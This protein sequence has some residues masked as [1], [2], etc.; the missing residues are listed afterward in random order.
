MELCLVVVE[1]TLANSIAREIKTQKTLSLLT[2]GL[3][4]LRELVQTHIPLCTSPKIPSMD[5]TPI[6]STPTRQPLSPALPDEFN[7][8]QIKGETSLTS[9]QTYIHLCPPWTRS[10]SSGPCPILSLEE[11]ENGQPEFL[12]GRKT[13][14]DIPNSWTGTNS[15]WHSERTFAPSTLTW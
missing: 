12:N 4:L 8:D 13:I 15:T 3:Q 1:Q 11:Q 6:W 14:R 2:D 5:T 10:K 7:R 9:C